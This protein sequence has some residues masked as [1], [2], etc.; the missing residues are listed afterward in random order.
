MATYIDFQPNDFFST[1]LWTGNS[2]STQALTGV[3]FQ[4]DF[5]WVKKRSSA[6]AH[7][8]TDSVRGAT[9]TIFT[10]VTT[11]ETARAGGLTAFGADGFTVGADGDFNGGSATFV[12]WNWK[13]GT[14]SGL[15]RGNNNSNC[16]FF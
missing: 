1:L 6:A 11:A 16:L 8:L 15:I 9:E 14:T 10:D 13:A 5:V 3:G 4:P 12:G 7:C 2:P